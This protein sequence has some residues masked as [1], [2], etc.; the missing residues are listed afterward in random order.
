[1]SERRRPYSRSE[2]NRAL[3]ANAL[4]QPFNVVLLTLVLIAGLVLEAFLPLL[5]VGLVVYG[6][7]AAR[8]YFDEDEANKVLE[9]ERGR[10][11]AEVEAGRLDPGAL[12]EPIARLLSAAH[13]R[14]ARIRDAIER[15]ELPYEE[16]SA[17]VDRFVRAMEDG[18]R[19]AQLLYEALEETPPGWVEQ[20]L[21]Q[22]KPDPARAELA[23]ALETQLAVLR[24]MELQLQRFYDEM[25]RV[26][27]ELDTERANQE[28]LAGEVRTLREEVG[29]VAAGM[30]EA[31]ETG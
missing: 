22:V 12:A 8:T 4:T 17:E 30:S 7:A 11:R 3:V 16:V 18:A 24:R 21:A 23:S 13:Q 20:R 19:R 14:E 27:V 9:R 10:R 2:Y 6:I 29:A 26:L 15:A 1:M 5:A 31:Y 28:R 25:E